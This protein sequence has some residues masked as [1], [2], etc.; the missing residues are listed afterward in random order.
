MSSTTP[1][2]ADLDAAKRL[3]GSTTLRHWVIAA[4]T[5][6]MTYRVEERIDTKNGGTYLHC[7]CPSWGFMRGR[8][9]DC[10]HVVNVKAMLNPCD[11]CSMP[12]G[13]HDPL[14]EH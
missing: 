4:S 13:Q 8:Q 5:P 3:L 1:S 2:A 10:K 14:I 6:G 7:Q 12:D 11:D 9:K